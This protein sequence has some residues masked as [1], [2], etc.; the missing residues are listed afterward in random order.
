[1][2]QQMHAFA[3]VVAMSAHAAAAHTTTH[4]V[5]CATTYTSGGGRG[6]QLHALAKVDA[7]WMAAARTSA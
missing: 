5:K 3:R 4:H 2:E 1:M 7:M 6:E